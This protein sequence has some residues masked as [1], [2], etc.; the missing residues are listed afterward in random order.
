MAKKISAAVK[1]ELSEWARGFALLSDPTRLGVLK[2]LAA[3]PRNVTALCTALGLKQPTISP[4]LGLL[5]M[6]RL[7]I[8]TRQGKSV[9]YTTNK[10]NLKELTSAI[11]KLTPSK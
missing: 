5:R 1:A 3:G 2:L 8:G 9:V 11:A 4:H 7:V 10:K 6:G